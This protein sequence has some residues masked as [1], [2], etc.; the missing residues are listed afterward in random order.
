MPKVSVLVPIY[1]SQ[2]YLPKCLDSILYQ[3]FDNLQIVLLDDGSTD[4]SYSIAYKYANKDSRIELYHQNN[5][6]V[7]DTRN[8]LLSF[9]NGDYILYPS[10]RKEDLPSIQ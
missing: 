8:K 5:T 4:N 2:D 10:G 9:T 3:T 1:N 6:G 7:A